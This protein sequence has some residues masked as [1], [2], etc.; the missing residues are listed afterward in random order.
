MTGDEPK[1]ISG[2]T[3]RRRTTRSVR[4][5]E[6]AARWLITLGGIGT[7]VAVCTIFA[8][9][10]SVVLPLVRGADVAPSWPGCCARTAP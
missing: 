7:I 1:S 10:V 9:L 6:R 2:W 8:F 3:R 5:A 4:V